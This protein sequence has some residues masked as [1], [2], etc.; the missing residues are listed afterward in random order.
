MK[1]VR[2]TFASEG[3]E[4]VSK[5]LVDMG[6]SFRVEPV[7]PAVRQQAAAEAAP[8]AKPRAPAKPARK[9]SKAKRAARPAKPPAAGDATGAERLRAAI[10][11]S[12][13]TYRA[14]PEPSPTTPEAAAPIGD[15]P[16]EQAG[17]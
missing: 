14:P 1:E 3:L 15:R 16:S 9:A 7:G 13:T 11:Q 17:D 8:A 12:G 6:L 4:A 5:L 2:L 10:A